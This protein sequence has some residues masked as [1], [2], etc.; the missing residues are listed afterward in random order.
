MENIYII[1]IF[2]FLI[3][4]MICTVRK[5]L[6]YDLFQSE[7]SQTA[8]IKSYMRQNLLLDGITVTAEDFTICDA[9]DI[10]KTDCSVVTKTAV[11]TLNIINSSDKKIYFDLPSVTL[12]SGKWV[13]GLSMEL[14][15]ELN[16]NFDSVIYPGRNIIIKA[17]YALYKTQFS[18]KEWKNIDEKEFDIIFEL[19]PKKKFISLKTVNIKNKTINTNKIS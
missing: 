16:K 6:R 13:Q 8:I 14:F 9:G 19:T 15:F 18:S 10:T 4:A 11:V 5:F 1:Y 3:L 7:L 2:V 12:T 17:P